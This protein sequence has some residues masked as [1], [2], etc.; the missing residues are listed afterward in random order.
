MRTFKNFPSSWVEVFFLPKLGSKQRWLL[1]ARKILIPSILSC[2]V[3]SA[4]FFV[5]VGGSE[6]L[7]GETDCPCLRG[8]EMTKNVS[9][10]LAL[11]YN[12]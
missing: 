3:P 10:F 7:T 1:F 6:L 5:C 9:L 12:V 8:L 4:A 11:G 2:K